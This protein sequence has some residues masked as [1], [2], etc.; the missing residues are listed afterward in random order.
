MVNNKDLLWRRL[1]DAKLQLDVAHQQI[2]KA[3]EDKISGTVPSADGNYAHT[4]TLHD[5]ELAVTN[6]LKA[7]GDLKAALLANQQVDAQPENIEVSENGIT[8]REREVLA[9][10]AAGKSSKEIA[11]HLGVAFRTVV[12][13]RYHLQTK[14]KVHKTA[15][16]TRLALR[17]GLIEL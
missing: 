12:A 14:L 5:H 4:L 9:L 13:H 11:A 10:I 3:K 8:P 16:L 17:M 1:Q 6:Y 7:L 2:T 15:D